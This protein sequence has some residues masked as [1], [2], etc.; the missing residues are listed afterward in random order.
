M[1]IRL[2]TICLNAREGIDRF[3][4]EAIVGSTDLVKVVLMPARALIGL[5]PSYALLF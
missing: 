1:K 2:R 5:G 3:G 4:T